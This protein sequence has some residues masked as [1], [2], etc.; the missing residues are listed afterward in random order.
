MWGGVQHVECIEGHSNALRF[1]FQICTHHSIHTTDDIR[2][3]NDA[4]LCWLKHT[5]RSSK[6][7]EMPRATKFPHKDSPPLPTFND[8]S[9]PQLS[10]TSGNSEDVFQAR[11]SSRG[12][13]I[14]AMQ[15]LEEDMVCERRFNCLCHRSNH[16]N[17]GSDYPNSFYEEDCLH[18]SCHNKVILIPLFYFGLIELFF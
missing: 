11:L 4:D 18:S 7:F 14:Q 5:L 6:A 3:M 10:F 15:P 2:N 12:S 17:T 9:P 1:R 13:C 16:D 8:D